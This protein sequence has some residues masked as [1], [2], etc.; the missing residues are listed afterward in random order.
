MNKLIL[1]LILSLGFFTSMYGQE[2]STLDQKVFFFD[3]DNKLIYI[4]FMNLTQLPSHI[5]IKSTDGSYVIYP[6]DDLSNHT[7][8]ELNFNAYQKGSYTLST[9]KENTSL[10]EQKIFV[11]IENLTFINAESNSAL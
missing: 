7:L 10:A 6:V 2:V 11:S 1:I 3:P 5:K 4:D 9:W 8:L